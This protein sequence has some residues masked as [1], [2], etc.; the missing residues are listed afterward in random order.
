MSFHKVDKDSEYA[1]GD[2]VQFCAV[3]SGDGPSL[4]LSQ[5]N[6]HWCI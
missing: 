3:L 5:S 4:V 2:I 6:G 1:K